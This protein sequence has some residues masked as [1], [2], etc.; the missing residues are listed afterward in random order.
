MNILK[1]KLE[2]IEKEDTNC[3]EI[4]RKGDFVTNCYDKAI[5]PSALP[6]LIHKSIILT[7]I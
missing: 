1:T 3:N 2:N 5:S 6:L 4:L 7:N